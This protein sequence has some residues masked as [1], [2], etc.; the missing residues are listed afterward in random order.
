MKKDLFKLFFGAA[1]IIG[2][3]YVLFLLI[4]ILAEDIGGML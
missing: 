1:E 3:L 4:R 2:L